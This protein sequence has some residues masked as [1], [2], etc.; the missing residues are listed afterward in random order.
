MAN[1]LLSIIATTQ[2]SLLYAVSA[3]V[4]MA[5]ASLNQTP[6]VA[7]MTPATSSVLQIHSNVPVTSQGFA[8]V[9]VQFI[10]NGLRISGM[11]FSID[12]D[13]TCLFFDPVDADRNGIPDN[14][15]FNVPNQFSISATFDGSDA[16]GEI[17]IMIVDYSPPFA[18]FP[19]QIVV[20]IRLGSSC[21]PAAGDSVT[22]HVRFS[23]SPRPS[24]STSSGTA[25]QGTFIDGSVLITAN[26]PVQT[27]IPTATPTSAP[28]TQPTATIQPTVTVEPSPTLLPTPTIPGTIPGSIPGTIPSPT[29]ISDRGK[30]FMPL[31]LLGRSDAMNGATQ[32]YL[33]MITVDCVVSEPPVSCPNEPPPEPLSTTPTSIGVDVNDLR[34]RWPQP[35]HRKRS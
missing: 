27:P 6:V 20:T 16:D 31:I 3:I 28:T 33:P 17:D 7:T 34:E 12:Y 21:T 23:Q 29:P 30:V 9:P 15:L 4:I 13:H 1:H 32:I 19:D 8:L 18:T 26:S 24:L 11:L 10:S 35:F 22:A 25:A 5:L 14:L 2:R